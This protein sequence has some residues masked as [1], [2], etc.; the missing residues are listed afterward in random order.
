[1]RNKPN[2]GYAAGKVLPQPS[3]LHRW[4]SV[5]LHC[6]RWGRFV[7][8]WECLVAM[9][10]ILTFS[11]RRG[12]GE[13]RVFWNVQAKKIHGESLPCSRPDSRAY[14]CCLC[15]HDLS[16]V[17]FKLCCIIGGGRGGFYWGLL[18]QDLFTVANNGTPTSV[19]P[20]AF[21]GFTDVGR[22]PECPLLA[23]T[24]WVAFPQTHMACLGQQPGS[25]CVSLPVEVLNQ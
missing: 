2:G 20:R 16:A 5:G 7:Y 1:M 11:G 17:C 19:P 3:S 6:P 14:K 15:V 4:P 12:G 9:T 13:N 23:G 8:L 22:D 18:Y 10:R 21:R 25:G 24:W